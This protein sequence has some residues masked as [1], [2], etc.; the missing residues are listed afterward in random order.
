VLITQ[1]L[2]GSYTIATN[3][4]LARITDANADA[5]GLESAVC[6]N[7]RAGCGWRGG[8]GR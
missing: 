7:G 6:E 1:A 3:Q 4:G 2:G 5:L 8:E